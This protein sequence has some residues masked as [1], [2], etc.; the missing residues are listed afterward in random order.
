MGDCPA[1][2]R[3]VEVDGLAAEAGATYHGG[4]LKSSGDESSVTVYDGIDGSAIDVIDFFWGEENTG[5]HHWIG[6]GIAVRRGLY[7]DIGSRVG[8]FTIYYRPPPRET[9]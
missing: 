6:E 1:S 9:G 8:D 7:V 2:H 4:V 5:D 3:R